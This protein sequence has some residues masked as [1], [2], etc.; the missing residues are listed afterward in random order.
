MALN[1]LRTMAAHDWPPG[2]HDD[3]VAH[4][5]L[6]LTIRCPADRARVRAVDPSTVD[7]PIAV[8]SVPSTDVVVVRTFFGSESSA[9]AGTPR[10]ASLIGK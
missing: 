9:T 4:W 1:G 2:A 5:E 10:P 8:L 7:L 6:R 3:S